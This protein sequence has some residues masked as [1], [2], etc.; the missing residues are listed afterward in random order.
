MK[1]NALAIVSIVLNL[2]LLWT[3]YLLS[4]DVKNLRNDLRHHGQAEQAFWIF[5]KNTEGARLVQLAQLVLYRIQ[6]A[7]VLTARKVEICLDPKGV[8]AVAHIQ[9]RRRF[10]YRAA[11]ARWGISFEN[12]KEFTVGHQITFSLFLQSIRS[13]YG[14]QGCGER[15][16]PF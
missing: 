7:V 2:V 10:Q 11:L 6:Q 16:R 4:G 15:S 12:F 9:P 5:R 14:Q 8:A 1:K 13:Q 3:V